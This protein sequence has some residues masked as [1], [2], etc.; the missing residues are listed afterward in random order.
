MSIR[1]GKMRPY[2]YVGLLCLISICAGVAGRDK[3]SGPLRRFARNSDVTPSP[4]SCRL[5]QWSD[6]S[7]CLPCTNS[8]Q[9]YRGL[10]QP[11]KYGGMICVG[12]LWES[13][14][15]KSPDTCA[16]T[17]DCGSDFQCKESGRCIRKQ[18]VCNGEQD[19]QD[20]SD[21][22]DCD[23]LD[24]ERSFCRELFEIPG[25][26]RAVRGFNILTQS[27]TQNVLDHKYFG[28]QC[29]YIYNGEWRDLRY[30]P[31]CEQMYY[32]DDEK[33]FRKPFNFHVYQFLAR[34]DTGMSYET[35]ED[36]K[37]V[38]DAIQRENSFG[39]GLSFEVR[40]A[41]SP[42]GVKFGGS[43]DRKTNYLKNITSHTEKNLQFVRVATKIQTARFRMRTN[44]LMLDEEMFQSLMELPDTYNYGLYVKFINDYGTH[45]ITSGTMGG[46]LDSVVVLDKEIMQRKEITEEFVSNCLG[47]HIGLS[48]ATDDKQLEGELSVKGK[49]CGTFGKDLEVGKSSDGVIKDVITHIEGG[50]TG[51]AGVIVNVFNAVTYRFW[52]RSLKFNPAV[53]DYELLPIHEGL[54]LTGISILVT[55]YT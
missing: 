37:S 8:K 23:D 2:I 30:D 10:S 1:L 19:C 4:L 47:G 49:Y 42:V 31:T 14:I 39:F 34:A 9:R 51:S 41:E 22:Q 50:D 40:P 17:N 25:A 21:E 35:Y 36:S 24:Q 12:N 7:H 28:G 5:G 45:F 27:E 33:F 20:G 55:A 13:I 32:A 48:F 53:I 6:W 18:M 54:Q 43:F 16:P 29:E 15:C 38:V 46:T 44:S 11:A 26:E 52:G 3:N